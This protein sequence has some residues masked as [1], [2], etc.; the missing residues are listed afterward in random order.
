VRLR[1]GLLSVRPP[2][3]PW[4]PWSE[5]RPSFYR[6]NPL[7]GSATPRLGLGVTLESSILSFPDRGPWGQASYR[8]NCS[9]RIYKGLFETLRPSVSTPPGRAVTTA[10]SSA[11]C[12]GRGNI[13]AIRRT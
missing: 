2:F 5:L 9:G 11:T 6:D 12:A 7:A 8:G 3:P 1:I 13:S 10:R 4:L